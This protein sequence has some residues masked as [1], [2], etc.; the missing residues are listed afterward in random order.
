MSEITSS[1][2]L[3]VLFPTT[4]QNSQHL[5]QLPHHHFHQHITITNL[6]S[7][8]P[9]AH[10][11][12]GTARNNKNEDWGDGPSC[13]LP[14]KVPFYLKLY[15]TYNWLTHQPPNP[16]NEHVLLVATASTILLTQKA[17]MTARFCGSVGLLPA[18]TIT[19]PEMSTNAR[20]GF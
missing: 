10:S 7:T 1:K 18:T 17:S 5:H 6:S 20:F 11:R 14:V 19:I 2:S 13:H 12:K 3:Q 15:S 9:Q 4:R 16:E 8:T